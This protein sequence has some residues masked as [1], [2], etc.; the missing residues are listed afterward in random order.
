MGNCYYLFKKIYGENDEKIDNDL[1]KVNFFKENEKS[2]Y[3][4]FYKINHPCKS[5][6]LFGSKFYENN[7]DNCKICINFEEMNLM[8]FYEV[9]DN[10]HKLKVVLSLDIEKVTDLSYIFCGCSM[11]ENIDDFHNLKLENITSLSNMFY[12]CSSLKKLPDIS[13]WNT[14]NVKDMSDMFYGC[15]SLKEIP[16]I[17]KWDTSNVTDM[18]NIFSKCTQLKSLPDISKWNT[19]KVSD[20]SYMFNDCT[21]LKSLCPISKWKTYN[22]KNMSYMFYNCS[23][24][25]MLPYISSWDTSNVKNMSYMFYGCSSLKEIDEG[26]SKWNTDKVKDISNMFTN[27]N[28][29][30]KVPDI[31]NWKIYKEN[32]AKNIENDNTDYKVKGS[33]ENDN[34]KYIPQIIMKF[35]EANEIKGN[36][37]SELRKELRNIIGSDNFSII[38]VKRGSLTIIIA[39][40]F[41]ILKYLKNKKSLK[42]ITKDFNDKILQDVKTLSE[43]L[44]NSEFISLG[45]STMTPDFVDENVM[46]LSKEENKKEIASKILRL[47]TKN[48]T[49]EISN[50]DNILELANEIEIKDFENFIEK[51]S[52][53]ANEQQN[54]HQKFINKLEKYNKF[55]DE[56]VKKALQ[57]S[58]FEYKIIHIFVVYKDDSHYSKEK[59][60]CEN[61]G[62]LVKKI[63]FHGTNVDAVTGILSSQFRD[64]RI[65]ILGIGSYFTDSLDYAGYYAKETKEYS[66]IPKVGESFSVVGSE[67]YYDQYKLDKVYDCYKKN[68]GV[69]KNGVRCAF[70]DYN[71]R[72]MSKIELDGFKQ[73]KATEFLITDKSQIL[74]LY[75]ITLKRVEYLI[76]WRDINFDPSNP[77]GFPQQDF[78][79]MQEFHRKIKSFTLRDVNAKIYQM[80]NDD[81]ALALLKRK[82]Y[83]KVVIITNGYNDGQ[84]FILKSRQIIGGNPI[85]AVSSYNVANHIGWV[86]NMEN[87]LLLNGQDFHE[88]FF[89]CVKRNDAELYEELRKEIIQYYQKEIPDFYLNESTYNLFNFPNFKKDGDFGELYFN[90]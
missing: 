88:K 59:D 83:N 29:L 51:L 42:D 48:T 55:F 31:S 41:L 13:N 26:I 34:L 18:S 14:E 21:S 73:F 45:Q 57:N 47:G 16:D 52:L 3:S 64:A 82:K 76:I 50:D 9:K 89:D 79:K 37:I 38:D 63:L 85:A 27:C 23:S 71:T 78:L 10:D 46:D 39:L 22:V 60:K 5:I 44:K 84:N 8:E 28:S 74:P 87:V 2:T 11:L 77:N 6:R 30:Q 49:N 43:K 53:D 35:N 69:E 61:S 19:K 33:M 58:V 62:N 32:N 67:I 68:I 72:I 20:M 40:Q 15:S 17:T 75:G 12:G 66:R 36:T 65:H 4:M 81:D 90:D 86:K 70:A 1:I 25:E 56:E 24:L 7:K 80:L 54:N